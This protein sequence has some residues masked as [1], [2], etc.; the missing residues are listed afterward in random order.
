AL[1]AV[2]LFTGP[3]T[4]GREPMVLRMRDADRPVAVIMLAAIGLLVASR[5]LRAAL[6]PST[7]LRL[8]A[9][10]FFLAAVLLSLGPVP[11]SQGRELGVEGL[12]AWLYAYVP[13]FDGLRAPA[14]F[15][16]VG[17]VFL[18]ILAGY[19]LARLDR[20]RRGAL[21]M[22]AIGALFLV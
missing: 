7:N 18:M 15:A 1:V 19:G 11:E 12:Y 20:L 2:Q 22:T 5:R 10:L 6:V 4:L 13:G 21:V 8:P 17:Y 3:I 14:R 16:M 9:A